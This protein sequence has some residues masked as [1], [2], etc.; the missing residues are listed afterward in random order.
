MINAI[1]FKICLHPNKT[2]EKKLL[3]FSSHSRGLYNLLLAEAKRA[4]EEDGIGVNFKYLYSH[5]QLL[6]L[7]DDS[8]WLQELPEASAKQ[9]IKDL[10][11]AYKRTFKSGFGFP[12]FKSKRRSKLSFYQRTDN[13]YFKDGK[14]NLT[15]IGKVKCQKGNYP[16]SGY[17]NP[18]VSYDGKHWYLSFSIQECFYENLTGNSSEGIGI[19]LG[20]KNLATLSNGIVIENPNKAIP[21]LLRLDRKYNRLQRQ[22]SRKL[23][24]NKDGN[25]VN[26]TKNSEKLRKQLALIQR[27]IHNIKLNYYHSFT[28]TLVRTKPEFIALE[29]LDIKSMK[30]AA[31]SV[32]KFLQKISLYEIVREINYKGNYYNIPLVYV[33]RYYKSTQLCSSCGSERVML[34]SDRTYRCDICGNVIDRDLNSSINIRNEGYRLLTA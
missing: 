11:N 15:K 24:M 27:R 8:N 34:L 17:C 22:Y 31:N 18:R 1:G 12:K 33:D 28:T 20:I 25:H 7:R 16:S 26:Y 30:G 9:V 5:F 21:E 6:K 29:S 4:Y 10:V 23:E 19:D 14:V 2:Q 3:L 13:L 32:S